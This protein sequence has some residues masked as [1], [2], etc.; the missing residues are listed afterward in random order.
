MRP[1]SS[2]KPL[3]PLLVA[4]FVL[5]LYYAWGI[6]RADDYIYGLGMPTILVPGVPEGRFM[7]LF[8]TCGVYVTALLCLYFLWRGAGEAVRAIAGRLVAHKLFVPMVAALSFLTMVCARFALFGAYPLTD[9]ENVY[10]FV[11]KTLLSGRIKN[12][13][14]DFYWLFQYHLTLIDQNQWMGMYGI[15]HPLVL[16]LGL[17]TGAVNFIVPALSATTLVL[18]YLIARD[19][20]GG[21]TAAIALFLGAISPQFILTGGTLLG[22]PTAAFS[23]VLMIFSSWRLY[24]ERRWYWAFL[25]LLG[26]ILLI[27]NRPH[28][29]VCLGLPLAAFFLILA[30]TEKDRRSAFTVATMAGMALISMGAFFYVNFLQTGDPFTTAQYAFMEAWGR[31]TGIGFNVAGPAGIHTAQKGL[32]NLTLGLTRQN[33][34]LFGWP[35]SFLFILFIP[36]SR[37]GGFLCAWTVTYWAFYTAYYSPGINLTGPV[38]YYEMIVPAVLLSACGITRLDK[39]LGEHRANSLAKG[40]VPA[41][42]V[43]LCI[44]AFLMFLPPAL[45]SLRVVTRVSSEIYRSLDVQGAHHA[46][47]FAD[48]AVFDEKYAWVNFP[49]LSGPDLESEDR[50]FVRWPRDKEMMDKFLKKFPDREVWGVKPDDKGRPLVT[51]IR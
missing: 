34:W 24:R 7:L 11:A 12:P 44:S 32:A 4:V 19:H 42:I 35:L 31:G 27:L 16:A 37:F 36:V 13:S 29:W 17:L 39:L 18:I 43:S 41:A 40:V 20:F 38:Y 51:R 48:H 6:V 49:K 25:F 3:I 15:G 2:N 45:S 21:K 5:V 9:D 28:S 46:V 10:L 30:F 50:I 47:V 26:S 1:A 14:P 23:S 33:L 22:Y 8:E